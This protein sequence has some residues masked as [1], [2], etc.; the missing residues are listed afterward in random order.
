VD[1]P[2]QMLREYRGEVGKGSTRLLREQ[3][4]LGCLFRYS[5]QT[6]SP[7]SVPRG[8]TVKPTGRH[9]RFGGQNKNGKEKEK[10]NAN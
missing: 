5:S 10:Y 1:K 3:G 4:L 8:T 6:T 2:K 7:V 9:N